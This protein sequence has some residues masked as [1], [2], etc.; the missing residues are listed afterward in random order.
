MVWK[1][2]VLY[3]SFVHNCRLADP[4]VDTPPLPHAYNDWSC[5]RY[6][7][8]VS[9]FG[10]VSRRPFYVASYIAFALVLTAGVID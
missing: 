2:Q 1:G 5:D 9:V 8:V 10:Y 3:C 6:L 7:R 4:P